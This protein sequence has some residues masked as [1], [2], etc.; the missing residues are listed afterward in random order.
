M[1]LAKD[2]LNLEGQTYK[3]RKP[4]EPQEVRTILKNTKQGNHKR[5]MPTHRGKNIRVTSDV[6]SATV[7]A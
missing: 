1:I 2:C 7:K 4:S 6:M 3:Y 5:K